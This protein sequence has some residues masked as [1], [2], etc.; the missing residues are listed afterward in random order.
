MANQ[1]SAETQNFFNVRLRSIEVADFEFI[2]SLASNTSFFTV[3]PEYVLWLFARFHPDYCRVLEQ[4]SGELKGY[5]LAMPTSEP[6]NGIAIWQIAAVDQGRPFALE[7][8]AAYLRELALRTAA[9]SL[10]FTIKDG[11]QVL[12]RLVKLLATHFFPRAIDGFRPAA[13]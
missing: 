5:L 8:F 10:S 11:D 3:P 9:T 1:S 12:M 7:Y 4:A 13:I 2:R 6:T